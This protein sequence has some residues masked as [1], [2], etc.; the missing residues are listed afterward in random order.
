MRFLALFF[1]GFVAL[2]IDSLHAEIQD[3]TPYIVQKGDTVSG[4]LQR[5]NLRPLYG[6][7]EWVEKVLTLNRLN[8]ESSRNLRGEW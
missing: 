8:E 7:R 5:E 2:Q 1:V 6:T 4:I 3:Y